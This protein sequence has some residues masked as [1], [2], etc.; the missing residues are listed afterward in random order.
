MK[1][2]Y[3]IVVLGSSEA[4]F[5][6]GPP[7][8]AVAA[9]IA[10]ELASRV[11]SAHWEARA[12]V[13]YQ[14]ENMPERALAYAQDMRA[15]V[16]VLLPSGSALSEEKVIFSVYHRWPRLYPRLRSASERLKGVAGGGD[17]GSDSLR[18]WAFRFPS[19]VAAA[20]IGRAPLVRPEVAYEATRATLDALTGVP[21]LKTVVRLAVAT[22]QER[23]QA[24]TIR[25]RVAEYN[26]FVTGLCE[27]RGIPCFDPV[28]KLAAMGSQY[29]TVPDSLHS[30]LATR[31]LIA[32]WTAD[33]VI[34]VL[35]QDADGASPVVA[36]A[37][38]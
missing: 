1:D 38:P 16:V 14:M 5:T 6:E 27:A 13:L 15:E 28:E 19:R 10:S 23:D 29:E 11:P 22:F 25:A 7:E 12:A 35:F 34:E 18:G 4:T 24:E 26:R 31:R 20:V 21:G 8:N 30:T 36:Q 33:M 37:R 3:R 17:Q 32:G 9:L 2:S